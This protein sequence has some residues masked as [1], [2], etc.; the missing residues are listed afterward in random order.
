MFYDKARN[1]NMEYLTYGAEAFHLES[2]TNKS[3]V[4]KAIENVYKRII[5]EYI[6]YLSGNTHGE[7]AF[8][9]SYTLR[10][11]VD[12]VESL[13]NEKSFPIYNVTEQQY[14]TSYNIMYVLRAA[15]G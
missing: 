4:N 3:L 8:Q 2:K 5:R 6:R 15:S 11:Y 14:H 7:Q 9:Y 1:G 10:K 13:Y 12:N